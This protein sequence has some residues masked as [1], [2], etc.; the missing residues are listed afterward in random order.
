MTPFFFSPNRNQ[1]E[2]AFQEVISHSPKSG[3][4]PPLDPSSQWFKGLTEWASQW[5]E[6]N[7]GWLRDYFHFDISINPDTVKFFWVAFAWLAIAGVVIAFG[8]MVYR[9][10]LRRQ[11]TI[12]GVQ[13]SLVSSS[14]LEAELVGRMRKAIED[15]NLPLAMRL[16]WRLFLLRCRYSLSVTPA[17]AVGDL[18]TLTERGFGYDRQYL[19]MFGGTTF[20]EIILRE[21]DLL[22]SKIES[23][24]NVDEANR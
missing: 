13:E 3:G 21:Y 5:A 16:R 15:H 17:E 11:M 10:I 7:L 6:R 20:S 23:K 14:T 9:L 22:L 18:S 19:F 12:S 2:N 8:I 1:I 24:E 4:L